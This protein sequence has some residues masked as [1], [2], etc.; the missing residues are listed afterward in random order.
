MRL[1]VKSS[2]SSLSCET[3]ETFVVRTSLSFHLNFFLP[4]AWDATAAFGVCQSLS[5]LESSSSSSCNSCLCSCIWYLLEGCNEIDWRPKTTNQKYLSQQSLL[6]L[7]A[8]RSVWYMLCA[9]VLIFLL[10]NA[11]KGETGLKCKSCWEKR[12]PPVVIEEKRKKGKEKEAFY[13]KRTRDREKS[14]RQFLALKYCHLFHILFKGLF[15]QE[16]ITDKWSRT[17]RG[18]KENVILSC[19]LRA[20]VFFSL[21]DI[22]LLL[23][24]DLLLESSSCSSLEI[25]LQYSCHVYERRIVDSPEFH[26]KLD[27]GQSLWRRRKDMTDKKTVE[28]SRKAID[29]KT[30]SNC[31]SEWASS[32][33]SSFSLVLF[34]HFRCPRFFLLLHFECL[35]WVLRLQFLSSV[36][37]SVLQD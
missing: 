24:V 21:L 36:L 8:L 33:L 22:P 14:W 25:K 6:L 18:K 16:R 17:K 5:A 20:L 13:I 23:F 2:S 37:S 4:S 29:T 12:E 34:L 28:W 11:K 10:P 31:F 19:V 3:N 32:L 27:F 26:V 15:F 35:V 1:Q 30:E 7:L 9:H